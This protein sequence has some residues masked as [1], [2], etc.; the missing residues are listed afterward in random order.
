MIIDETDDTVTFRRTPAINEA[1]REH[2]LF[3]P[4]HP[5]DARLLVSKSYCI[6]RFA[7]LCAGAHIPD[8]GSFSFSYSAMLDQGMTIGRYCSIAANVAPLGPDHPTHWAT[9]SHMAY[10]PIEAIEAARREADLPVGPPCRH[11]PR[12]KMPIIGND[13]WIGQ[14]V[15]LKR[16][17]TIGDGAVIG[18]CSLVT[19]DVPPYAVVAGVPARVLRFRFDGPLIERFL[20]LGWWN[21]FEPH[22]QG[23][24]YD[25]PERFVGTFED[26]VAAGRIRPWHPRT[27]TLYD[28]VT[29]S[30]RGLA[31]LR[32]V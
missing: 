18:A 2:R 21:Y 7:T 6:Q 32:V 29:H 8:I 24:G 20:S 14:D 27:P 23:F 12:G 13:V 16:G 15:R 1:L 10:Q 31:R 3:L 9:T 25:D 30:S 5:D 11:E 4:N 28:I 17:I 19:K 22:F 26:A